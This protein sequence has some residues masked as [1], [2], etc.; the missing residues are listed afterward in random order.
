[1]KFVFIKREDRAIDIV[2]VKYKH[3]LDIFMNA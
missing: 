2:P 3:E 1:M